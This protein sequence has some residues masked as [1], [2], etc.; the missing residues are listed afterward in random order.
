VP[1]RTRMS[2]IA[3]YETKIGNGRRVSRR[4]HQDG[5][6]RVDEGLKDLF[7]GAGSIS[8][9]DEVM[10]L[11]VSISPYFGHDVLTPDANAHTP[12]LFR[13]RSASVHLLLQ[14]L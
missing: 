4:L 13:C 1:L 10:I 5:I 3:N 14:L 11:E 9:V 6:A 2:T 8:E 12:A 7:H